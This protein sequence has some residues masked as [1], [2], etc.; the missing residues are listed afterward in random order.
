MQLK[1]LPLRGIWMGMGGDIQ[2]DGL[3]ISMGMGLFNYE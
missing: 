1:P 2:G 3:E